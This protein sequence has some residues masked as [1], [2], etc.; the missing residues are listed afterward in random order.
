MSKNTT[1]ALALPGDIT[2]LRTAIKTAIEHYQ[3]SPVKN[4]NKLNESLAAALNFANY[5]QL[6][7]ALRSASE[8]ETVT[9]YDIAF[10]YDGEQYLIINGVRIEADLVHEGVIDYTVSERES[11]IDELRMWIGEA[12]RSNEPRRQADIPLMQADLETLLASN[13]EFVLEAYGTN[14]FV[15]G[16]LEPVEF[17]AI[18]DEMIACAKAYYAEKIGE[19]TKTGRCYTE[20]AA[21]YSGEPVSEVY[22]NELVLINEDFLAD[23]K[24]AIGMV[25]ERY[26][27]TVPDGFMVAYAGAFGEYVPIYLNNEDE[28]DNA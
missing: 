17:N 1:A 9:A 12:T 16:D 25:A 15:A 20:A 3:G 27:G 8:V 4:D 5:D 23:D 26:T 11:R 10:D 2:S 7:A 21:Y 24:L 6:A 13:E 14:G 28:E 22:E 18:C 19:L